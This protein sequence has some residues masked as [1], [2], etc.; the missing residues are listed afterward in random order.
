MRPEELLKTL[1]TAAALKTRTRHCWTQPERKESIADH[2][3]RLALMTVLLE[4]EPEFQGVD[5]NRVLRMCLI[6]DL[7]EAFSGDIPAFEKSTDDEQSEDA[8]YLQWVD[9]FPESDR[10]EWRSLLSEMLAMETKEARIYKALDKLEAIISHNE[11]DIGTWLPLEYELQK[12]YGQEN[13][14]ASPYFAE[15]RNRIDQWTDEKI[16]SAQKDSE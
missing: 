16:N 1:S 11:S 8:R 13:M 7:G 15:L 5:M 3:W 2:S 4:N 9:T 10:A 12:T 6:H 14:D